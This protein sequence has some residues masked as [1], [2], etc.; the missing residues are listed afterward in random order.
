[1]R[2]SVFGRKFSRTKNERRRLFAG[3]VRDLLIRDS[4][5]TTL[6]KA[7]AVQ[8]IIEK[9][10]TKAR[11]G[12]DANK[13]RAFAVLTDRKL[14]ED[15]FEQAKTR[16][17][18]RTSGFTRIVKAGLRRGDSTQTAILSFV[19]E[20]IVAEVV[21]PAKAE[22]KEDLP[23]QAGKKPVAKTTPKTAAKKTAVKKEKKG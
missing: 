23:A 21:K 4:I 7:K 14:T 1:M 11:E 3:L 17:A 6:A 16:F 19:D 20:K 22:V 8:P 9:L 12:S 13:R 15:L 2:H 10:I 18:T 5:T